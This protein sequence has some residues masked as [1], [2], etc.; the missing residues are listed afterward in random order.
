[1]SEKIVQCHRCNANTKAGVRCKKKTLR[2]DKCWMH[3]QLIDNLRIKK[4]QLPNTGFGLY[5][6]K[7]PIRK[8]SKVIE[9]TGNVSH[10]ELSGP[11]VLE[12]SRNR[13]I[14]AANTK[15][16]GGFANSCRTK[17][18]KA[19]NCKG[20]NCNF[21]YDRRNKKAYISSVKNIKP[22]EELFASYGNNYFKKNL[23]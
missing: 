8:N 22:N 13:F 9:Y 1:M 19:K 10:H 20:N 15:H 6:G 21:T 17:D 7:S 2:G 16:T 12:V 5:S 3:L 23:S 4:S 14:D 11:Y 18:K